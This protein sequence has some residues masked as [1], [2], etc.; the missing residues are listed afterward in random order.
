MIRLIVASNWNG[1]TFWFQKLNVNW[2]QFRVTPIGFRCNKIFRSS[3]KLKIKSALPKWRKYYEGNQLVSRL[4]NFLGWITWWGVL[5]CTLDSQQ[6][7]LREQPGMYQRKRKR[8][9]KYP[10][11][12][13]RESLST[14]L[15]C[16]E[17][18]GCIILWWCSVRRR[19]L[20]RIV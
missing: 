20:T 12:L 3:C 14:Q 7:L 2:P 10:R 5:L 1:I 19:E 8:T 15:N 18:R 4:A 11:R 9:K 16:H 13:P 17:F 6:R